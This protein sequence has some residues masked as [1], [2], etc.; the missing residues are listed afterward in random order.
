M[1]LCRI[2]K[3]KHRHTSQFTNITCNTKKIMGISAPPL[4]STF[5]GGRLVIA[6]VSSNIFTYLG[7]L[8]FYPPDMGRYWKLPWL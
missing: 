7:G 5:K 3:R 4:A 8:T 2:W 1:N 6:K